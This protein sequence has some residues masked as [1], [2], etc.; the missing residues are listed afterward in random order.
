MRTSTS[1]SGLP[2]LRRWRRRFS[3]TSGG[4]SSTW[5]SGGTI[6][7]VDPVSV[8]PNALMNCTPGIAATAR[9]ITGGGIDAPP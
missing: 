3:T 6:A 1:G 9:S 5:S 4:P 2:M 8:W 7:M